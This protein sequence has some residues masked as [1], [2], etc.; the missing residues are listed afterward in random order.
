LAGSSVASSATAAT[1]ATAAFFLSHVSQNLYPNL[2]KKQMIFIANV[3]ITTMPCVTMR[4]DK[5]LVRC[6]S[7]AAKSRPRT[8]DAC[9]AFPH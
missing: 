6:N 2:S 5:A 7:T 9:T 3:V 4:G 8:L 1:A